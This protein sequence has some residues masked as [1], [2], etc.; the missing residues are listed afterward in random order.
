MSVTVFFPLS[1]PPF[2]NFFFFLNPTKD[3]ALQINLLDLETSPQLS[4]CI[5]DED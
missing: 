3:S 2:Q 5:F 1:F 4:D